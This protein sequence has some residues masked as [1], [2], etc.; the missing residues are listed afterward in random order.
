MIIPIRI[1]DKGSAGPQ[2]VVQAHAGGVAHE[3]GL[4]RVPQW[5]MVE[6]QGEVVS[7]NPLSGQHLG[8]MTFEN[9][10]PVLVIGNHKLEGKLAAEPKPLLVLRK[11]VTNANVG[12]GD[13]VCGGQSNARDQLDGEGDEGDGRREGRGLSVEYRI[14]GKVTRKTIFKTRPKPLIRKLPQSGGKS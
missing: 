13:D 11:V 2:D 7:T 8:N 5:S 12:N 6:L 10:K 1:D 14:V 9:G 4:V 3:P